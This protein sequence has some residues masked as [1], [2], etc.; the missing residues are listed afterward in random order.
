MIHKG[1]R[2]SKQLGHLPAPEVSEPF[3]CDGAMPHVLKVRIGVNL[4][5]V[6]RELSQ[7]F[8]STPKTSRDGQ[9]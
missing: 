2:S 4:E 7:V 6:P 3:H 1:P 8:P 9:R 5:L